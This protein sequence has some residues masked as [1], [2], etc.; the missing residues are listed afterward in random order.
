MSKIKTLGAFPE[1]RAAKVLRQILSAIDACH[2]RN[3]VHRD[4][5][6]ENILFKASNAESTVKVIDFGRSKLLKAKEKVTEYAGSVTP[7][8]KP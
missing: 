1:R 6:P 4:L 2:K 8:C 5:K 3:I 7:P